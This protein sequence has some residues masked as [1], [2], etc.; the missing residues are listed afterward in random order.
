MTGVPGSVTP[1]LIVRIAGLPAETVA[2]FS[3][4]ALIEVIERRERLRERLGEVRST[5][6]ECLHGAVRT[7]AREDRRFLLS[8]K[9]SCFN[10][11]ALKAFRQD[12]R[13][14]FLANVA[15]AVVDT[16]VIMEGAVEEVEAEVETSYRRALRQERES[17]V[18]LLANRA[19]VRGIALSSPDIA[20]HL[21]RLIGREPDRFGRREKRLCLTLLRYASR[22][23]LKLSPFSTLTRTGL[24]RVTD[25]A[26]ADF[27]FL[28]GASWQERSTISLRR[29]LL[30]QCSSL[31]LRCGRFTEGLQV[32]INETLTCGGNGTCA[33]FRP[34]RWEFDDESGPFRY[35]EPSFVR[36]R[37][38]GP[39]VPWMLAELRGE[40]RT[41][42][43]HLV[44]RAVAAFDTED[45][46][47]IVQG[48]AGLLDIGFLSLILPWSFNEPDLEHRILTYL[49]A[50]PDVGLG[51]FRDR[52]RELI[53]LLSG[54][55]ETASPARILGLGKRGVEGLFRALALP[56]GVDSQIEF[57]AYDK[58]FE[59]EVFLLPEP[60]PTGTHEIVHLARDRMRALVEDLEPLA[61]WID[62]HSSVHDLLHTLAAFGERRW[63]G[64]KDVG[65]LEFFGA[66]QPLFNAYLRYRAGLLA[67]SPASPP[68]FN[69]LSLESVRGL[70]RWREY[71]A[72]GLNDCFRDA[73]P[74][75]RLCSRALGAL[76]DQVPAVA[77][78]ACA[79]CAFVQP[80]DPEGRLWVLSS[81]GEGFG[82]F[83]SRFTLGMDDDT[84]AS[85]TAW[86]TP[87]SVLELEGEQVELVDMACPGPRTINVH[88]QQTC[89]V[90]KMPGEHPTVALERLV[91]L[92]DLRVRLRGAELPPVLTDAISRRLLPISLGSLN[93]D[94]RPTLLKFLSIFGS[95]DLRRPL[96]TRA[97]REVDGVQVLDRHLLGPIVY[98]RKK[99]RF[100]PQQLLSSIE[101]CGEP[102]AY[103]RVNRW[104]LGQGI[105]DQVFVLEPIALAGSFYH[106]KPQYIDFSSPSFVQIFRSILR[107][108]VRALVLEEALPTPD[109]FPV[110][111][112]GW[113]AEVQLESFVFHR[114]PLPLVAYE[115]RQQPP[116][117]QA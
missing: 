34:G 9:R 66:A 101:G 99:W 108:N 78:R 21:D 85:W 20:Q 117:W 8:V 13:W 14:P 50:L 45:R 61:C 68:G 19:F 54:Y 83:G 95:R 70:N 105:P 41:I 71:V 2:P 116:A 92:H 69:P 107:E 52:L 82:R 28:P 96:P 5:L 90:L 53:G 77:A 42:H 86:F 22:A 115:R 36:V 26:P 17:L 46:D 62:L 84:R 75:Q 114:E 106:R 1:P 89:R 40:P 29:E 60:A 65:L 25:G 63:P 111:G 11:G 4:A 59:E 79:F 35:R 73:G 57:K 110:R 109:R 103:V 39:L 44:E 55:A 23:A 48:I 27:A 76:L 43:R 80:V 100:E 32:S 104:R 30:E 102:A 51:D 94:A 38:E 6:V 16:A 112:S 10:G 98:S 18:Q 47:L 37:L 31:L 49:D 91:H 113:A 74:A 67:T 56:A 12:P 97:P 58:T 7:A 64:A 72:K 87:L 3:H 81:L 24:G 15:S 93:T 88:A 33:F